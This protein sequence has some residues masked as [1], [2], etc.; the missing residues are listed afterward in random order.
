VETLVLGIVITRRIGG[1]LADHDC[2][3]RPEGKWEVVI[4]RESLQIDKAN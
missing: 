2:C 3:R 4:D 1:E